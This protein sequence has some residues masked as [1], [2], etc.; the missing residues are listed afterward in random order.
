MNKIN[1]IISVLEYDDNP[2][3]IFSPVLE[4]KSN[5][6]TINLSILLSI[7]TTEFEERD[8][9]LCFLHPEVDYVDRNQ[10]KIN[11][12]ILNEFTIN[13]KNDPN[14]MNIQNIIKSFRMHRS[15]I[16]FNFKKIKVCGKGSYTILLTS[17]KKEE[18]QNNAERI[19][20]NFIAAYTFIVK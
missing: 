16:K 19:M 4:I 11:A 14:R 5:E 7:V 6:E 17:L 18:I 9:T 12:A 8:F 15:D 2:K 13:K 1:A 10:I 20:N 3:T